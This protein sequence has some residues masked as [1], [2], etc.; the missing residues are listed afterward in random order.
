V[1]YIRPL[2]TQEM[3]LQRRALYTTGMALVLLNGY[4]KCTSPQYSSNS[5][6]NMQQ[7]IKKFV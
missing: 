5:N 7:P 6:G 4:I 3:S 2:A 1:Q